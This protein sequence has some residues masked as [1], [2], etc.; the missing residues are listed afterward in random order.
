MDKL[1]RR[2]LSKFRRGTEIRVGEI[3]LSTV[4]LTTLQG[5]FEKPPD[6]LMYPSYDVQYD[7]AR[8]LQPFIE[9]PLDLEAYEY[10]L[11][12]ETV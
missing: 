8:A 12:S 3:D 7:H 4:P 10:F 6:D 5:I 9:E 2:F 1:V 11:E